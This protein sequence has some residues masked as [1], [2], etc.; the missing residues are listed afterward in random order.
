MNLEY[1]LNNE[2]ENIVKSLQGLMKIRSVNDKPLDNMP[3]GRNIAE[4]LEYMEKLAASMGFKTRN[5]DGYV[6]EVEYG[7]GDEKGYIVSHLDVVPEGT[8][9]NYPPFDG[10]VVG[11]LIYGRGAVDN[12]G[13]S[14][15]VLYALK[16]VK[17]SG[18]KLNNRIILV[19]GTA[20]ETS[21]YD[22][23]YYVEQEGLP[24]WGLSPDNIYPIV[25]GEFGIL[26]AAFT[27]Q[28]NENIGICEGVKLIS[29]K[30]GQ[31]VNAVPDYCEAKIVIEKEF[32]KEFINKFDTFKANNK[33]KLTFEK[34]DDYYIIK[35]YGTAYHGGEPEWGV[36]AIP[37][38]IEYFAS[39]GNENNNLI[40]FLNFINKYAG[41]EIDGKSLGVYREDEI[42]GH[43]VSNFGVINIDTQKA[44]AIF[45]IRYPV[46]T[47]G[48]EIIESL[49][50]LTCKHDLVFKLLENSESHYV[51]ENS[52]FI[53]K[54]Q[55]VYTNITGKEAKLLSQRGG[56]YARM[57]G[58]RGVAF[59]P[60]EVGSSEVGNAHRADEF[61]SINILLTNAK[62]YAKTICELAAD[63]NKIK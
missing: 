18:I 9:W 58:D 35:S 27:K 4:A 55:R 46:K 5:V 43:S 44:E 38:V 25:N 19:F 14:I 34:E 26:V 56:T 10:T 28:I 53:K 30:G 22:V 21:M 54:L 31:A 63:L 61:I 57:L 7:E 47:K 33:R 23:K 41:Y 17:D 40:I 12:K 20:E 13:P 6:L 15:S 2:K 24:N 62:I 36:N 11:D 59:G 29:I 42:S 52:E 49:E 48:K 50:A 45:N 39:I 3:F 8:G 16:A 37:P 51:D 32:L 60:S 1:L